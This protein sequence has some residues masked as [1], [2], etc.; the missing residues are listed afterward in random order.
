M[1]RGEI[2]GS[3]RFDRERLSNTLLR[4][5]LKYYS[6]LGDWFAGDTF[7]GKHTAVG[8]FF[9]D[10]GENLDGDRQLTLGA[11]TGLRGYE[12][13]TFDGDKRIVLNLEERAHLVDDLFQLVS[14]GTAAFVDVGA[15]SRQSLGSMLGNDVYGDV[16]IGL[17]LGFPRATGS[18]IVRIDIAFPFRD[19]P[20][21]SGAFEP[22]IVFAAGQLF[23]ARLRSEQVGGQAAST[24][25]GFDR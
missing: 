17:R 21:G 20:D 12:A 22:R 13:F 6:V 25:V 7:L 8:N 15:A 19:G 14:I 4:T 3:S 10:F 9:I 23:G 1:L 24:G 2:G 18:G 11:D 5:E 16:G